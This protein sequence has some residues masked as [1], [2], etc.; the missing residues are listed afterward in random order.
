[1]RLVLLVAVF[2]LFFVGSVRAD[3]EF[4]FGGCRHRIEV[5]REGVLASLARTELPRP[6]PSFVDR[7]TL[8]SRDGMTQLTL[9]S[10]Q[11]L[12][13]WQGHFSEEDFASAVDVD[14]ITSHY[15]QRFEGPHMLVFYR[16][17]ETQGLKMNGGLRFDFIQGCI[18][19]THFVFIS[20][21]EWVDV[22]DTLE[23]LTLRPAAP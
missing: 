16:G 4:Q 22:A 1:M 3:E 17:D 13:V 21:V 10:P 23:G 2:G 19:V 6:T 15:P 18:L 7:V 20:D 5:V 11:M 14:E 9:A 8:Q 12:D